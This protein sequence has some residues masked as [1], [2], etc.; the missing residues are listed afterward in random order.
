M[1][2]CKED[3]W[4]DF[5]RKCPKCGGDV[6]THYEDSNYDTESGEEWDQIKVHC[7]QCGTEYSEVEFLGMDLWKNKNLKI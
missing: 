7:H 4:Y 3:D 1:I 5:L 6:H 2:E